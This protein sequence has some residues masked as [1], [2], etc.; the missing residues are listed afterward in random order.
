MAA[1][2]M[3]LMQVFPEVTLTKRRSACASV[4]LPAPVRP[5]MPT[6][7]RGGTRKM[8]SFREEV[9]VICHCDVMCFDFAFVRPGGNGMGGGFG[10]GLFDR[11][12]FSP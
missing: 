12:V 7:F 10:V 5:T 2:S 1:M 9:G 3:P 11:G 8:M 4:V 6:R